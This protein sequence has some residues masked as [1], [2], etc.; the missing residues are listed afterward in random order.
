M[1]TRRLSKALTLAALGLLLAGCSGIASVNDYE[2][3]TGPE[4]GPMGA[5]FQPVSRVM[6]ARCGTLDCHGQMSRPL[7]IFGQQGLRMP[8]RHPQPGYTTAGMVGT[9]PQELL[10]NYASMVGLEPEKM[11]KVA[12]GQAAPETLTLVRKPRL[13]E[14]HKGGKIWSQNDPG[15]ACL[16]KWLTDVTVPGSKPPQ[17]DTSDCDKELEHF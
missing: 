16:I 14:K 10:S 8:V 6:E 1:T 5:T 11:Q 9:T 12:D 2:T 17:L 13:T 4:F 7:R 3:I 15:D